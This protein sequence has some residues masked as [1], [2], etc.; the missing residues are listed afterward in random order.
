MK[1][2]LKIARGINEDRRL[3]AVE[4]IKAYRA[5]R[6]DK[7]SASRLQYRTARGK[8]SKLIPRS[9]EPNESS[10]RASCHLARSFQQERLEAG[11]TY[12]MPMS[13]NEHLVDAVMSTLGV[14]PLTGCLLEDKISCDAYVSLLSISDFGAMY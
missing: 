1:L 8:L 4:A 5:Y 2:V 14:C 3:A 9:F 12:E 6:H 10:A 13:N 11:R 7:S